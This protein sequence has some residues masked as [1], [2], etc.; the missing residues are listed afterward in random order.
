MHTSKSTHTHTHTHIQTPIGTLICRV[1]W[2]MCSAWHPHQPH[3]H[4]TRAPASLFVLLVCHTHKHTN[5]HT[6]THTHTH[7]NPPHDTL[8]QMYEQ[9]ES[10]GNV[11]S[12]DSAYKK[13]QTFQDATFSL[14]KENGSN[15]VS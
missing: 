10:T 9:V 1:R 4:Q 14:V 8:T 15:G 5:T 2:R 3:C 13:L 7:T 11:I 12:N 6:H